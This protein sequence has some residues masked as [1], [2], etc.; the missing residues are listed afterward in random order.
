MKKYVGKK[1][2]GSIAVSC[3][4]IPTLVGNPATDTKKIVLTSRILEIVDGKSFGIDG[5]TVGIILQVRKKVLEMI[6]GKQLEDGSKRGFYELDNHLYTVSDIEKLIEEATRDKSKA[7]L[8]S[9]IQQEGTYYTMHSLAELETK[10]E[11][12]KKQLENKLKQCNNQTEKNDLESLITIVKEQ[13]SKLAQHLTI[14]KKDFEDAVSPFLA[15]ARNTKEPMIMLI[16]ESC[17]KRNQPDSLL[18]DWAKLEGEEECNSLN[19]QVTS[20][21]IFYQFCTDL[22]DFLSDLVRSCPKAFKQFMEMKKKWEAEKRG[23]S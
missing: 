16:S 19:K 14:V 13:Q 10:V 8:L 20:F 12:S 2:L 21:N 23:K 3:T 9:K 4:I 7:T 17:E 6:D 15:N 11:N 22:N 5:E 1:V 18:L